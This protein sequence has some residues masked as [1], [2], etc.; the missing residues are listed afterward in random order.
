MATVPSIPTT[1]TGAI[2]TSA[3]MNNIKAAWDFYITNRPIC[4]VT[5]STTQ[6]IP[7][8]T[9]TN[10][11][12]DTEG[13]DNDNMHS[14]VTNTDQLVAVTAGW[15][16]VSGTIQFATNVTGY[17]YAQ[18]L[19]NNT[20][21]VSYVNIGTNPSGSQV[22]GITNTG[23]AFLNVGDFLTYSVAQNSGVALNLAAGAR[24][25]ALWEHQ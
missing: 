18:I 21:N 25:Q 13:V 22:T 8:G 24:L 12:F 9:G 5:R 20:T 1:A 10:V 14:T 11:L 16:S 7:N 2:G 17:R 4:V 6:S 15:Y 3:Q 23:L 19:I